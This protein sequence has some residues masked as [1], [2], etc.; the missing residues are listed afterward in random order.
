M[1]K[2]LLVDDEADILEFLRYNLEKEGY[3]ITTALNGKEAL[4]KLTEDTDLVI[5]DIM[6]PALDGFQVLERMKK[7]QR[8]KEIPVIFLTAKNGEIHE[9]NALEQGAID[10]IQKPV[11]PKKLL[12][13]VKS[14]IKKSD[15]KSPKDKYPL[16]IVFGPITID[17]EA[18]KVFIDNQEIYF[19]RKEFELLYFLINNPEKVFNR[20]FLL[21]EIWGSDIFVVER[22]V[23]VHIR[24]IREKLGEYADLIETIKGVG[25]K[26]KRV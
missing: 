7:D 9:I 22:T 18:Y 19:P 17:K 20:E 11:S 6:M 5:L 16:K 3:T 1:A 10:Y 2:I 8:F 21:R 13:R 26:L 4:D 24:K 15:S 12:A 25:Y 14:N 23:D